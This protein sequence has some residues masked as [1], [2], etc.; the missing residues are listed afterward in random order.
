MMLLCDHDSSSDS[1]K[2]EED[3]LELMLDLMEKPKRI[4]GPRINLAD[5]LSLECEQLFSL[6]LLY[7][8]ISSDTS[9]DDSNNILQIL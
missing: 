4:L 8:C 6:C 1:S 9:T 3:D 5:L 7:L 2:S